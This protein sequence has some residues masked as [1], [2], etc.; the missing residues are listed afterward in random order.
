MAKALRSGDPVRYAEL[1]IERPDGSR[2]WG[3]LNVEPV[4]NTS[5]KISGGIGCFQDI[6]VR[7]QTEARIRESEEKLRESER[8]FRELLDAL[9]AAVYTT[10]ARGRITFYNKAAV[11][12]WGYSPDVGKSTWCGSWRLRWPSGEPM[13]HDQCPMAVA[14]R[15]GRPI[16]GA[17][18]IAEW[19][20]GTR[21]P[22]AAYPTP[23]RDASGAVSG[24][25]NMLV[26]LTHRR[27]AERRQSL[28]INELNHRVKNTLATVQSIAAQSF[29]GESDRT[30]LRWF[31]GRL[32]ALSQAHDVLRR[33]NWEGASLGEVVAE[34]CA[35]LGTPD[36]RRF[37]ISGPEIRVP[38]RMALSLSMALHELCTNAAKYGALSETGGS[39]RIDWHVSPGE[40]GSRLRLRWEE[41]DGPPVAEPERKG[42]GSRLIGRG[43]ANE[44][45]ADVRLDYPR[46]GVVCEIDAPLA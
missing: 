3:L 1:A 11:D 40:D 2:I 45:G 33:E 17:E 44:L 9:P 4:R 36:K 43:L 46:E 35:P 6:T 10:D 23:L 22:F 26:D 21:V 41:R 29:R 14:L 7:K 27:Q 31:E 28:L 18:A 25:I 13:P 16:Q 30:A 15:E 8:R 20:D 5:G 24:A 32:L 42:F 19:P 12:L 39:V 37:E 34:A 38:P